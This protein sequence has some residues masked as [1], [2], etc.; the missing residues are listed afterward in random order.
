METKWIDTTELELERIE[1]RVNKE[2]AVH[3]RH[4]SF[5]KRSADTCWEYPDAEEKSEKYLSLLS[6]AIAKRELINGLIESISKT[7]QILQQIKR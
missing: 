3:D 4:I 5:L 1:R 7:R 2:I 6:D